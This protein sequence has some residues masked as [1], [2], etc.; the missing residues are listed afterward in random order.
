VFTRD[1]LLNWKNWKFPP[2]GRAVVVVTAVD[3]VS[4][5]KV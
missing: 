1:A 5:S 3:R 4:P 2:S